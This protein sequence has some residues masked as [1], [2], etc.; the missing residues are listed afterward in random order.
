MA[1]Y[2][3]G[4][5]ELKINSKINPHKFLISCEKWLN[6][7]SLDSGDCALQIGVSVLRIG[8]LVLTF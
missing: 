6:F 3:K 4:L 7:D 8:L 2:Y 1:K 5:I